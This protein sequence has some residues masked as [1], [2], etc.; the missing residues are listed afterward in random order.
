VLMRNIQRESLKPDDGVVKTQRVDHFDRGVI[1][2][3]IG[4]ESRLSNR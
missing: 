1:T 4:V 2:V 3:A